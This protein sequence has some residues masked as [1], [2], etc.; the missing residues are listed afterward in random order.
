L[1]SLYVVRAFVQQRDLLAANKELAKHLDEL[2]SR[3]ERKTIL[4]AE[5]DAERYGQMRYSLWAGGLG[6]AIY[7]WACIQGRAA[8]PS[9]DVFLAVKRTGAWPRQ[10]LF[11]NRNRIR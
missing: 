5:V 4:P 9:L 1:I 11:Y 6:F 7:L 3:I 8:F 2:E 10:N